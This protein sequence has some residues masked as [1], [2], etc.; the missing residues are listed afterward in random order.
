MQP[1]SVAV[2]V[3]VH[4]RW[5]L[6]ARF[7]ESF[8]RVAYGRYQVVVVDDGSPDDTPERLATDF[9]EVTV[10]R[11]DGRLWWAGATNRG[12]RHALK[13]GFHY[14]L[15]VNNDVT[16]HPDFLGRL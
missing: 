15:T 9:P 4:G 6:T 13:R 1:P 3:P 14:V 10:L 16:V 11:G 8:R 12:V 7:L 2:V 5:P